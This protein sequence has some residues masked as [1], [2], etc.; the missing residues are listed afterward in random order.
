[1]SNETGH[2][3][4]P[5]AKLPLEPATDLPLVDRAELDAVLTGSDG[6]PQ[7]WKSWACTRPLGHP[8]TCRAGTTRHV[9]AE[10]YP[11]VAQ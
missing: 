6:C 4:L 9:A 11:E 8:G 7:R 5:W 3:T 10:W 2:R 1:M